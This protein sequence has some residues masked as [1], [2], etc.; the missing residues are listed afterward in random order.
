MRSIRVL[1][2]GLSIVLFFLKP[3]AMAPRTSK[4]QNS[5]KATL[6]NAAAGSSAW[7][8]SSGEFTGEFFDI[9]NDVLAAKSELLVS[10]AGIFLASSTCY[11]VL[12][13]FFHST[14]L[15]AQIFFFY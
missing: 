11:S 2:K 14:F 3:S 10:N 7:S 1:D 4:N 9:Y 8:H 5:A 13:S 12:F 6:V 15:L